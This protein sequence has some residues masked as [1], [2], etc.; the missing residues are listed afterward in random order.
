MDSSLSLFLRRFYIRRIRTGRPFTLSSS[1]FTSSSFFF[2]FSPIRLTSGIVYLNLLYATSTTSTISTVQIHKRNTMLSGIFYVSSA[3]VYRLQTVVPIQ[4]P[5]ISWVQHFG[6]ILT[7]KKARILHKR[8]LH[9][10]KFHDWRCVC[11]WWKKGGR[12][13][14]WLWILVVDFVLTRVRLHCSHIDFALCTFFMSVFYTNQRQAEG[15]LLN[16]FRQ[17]SSKLLD[18]CKFHMCSVLYAICSDPILL[19]SVWNRK[20]KG[21]VFILLLLL[22]LWFF[23]LP[24]EHTLHVSYITKTI[25]HVYTSKANMPST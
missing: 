25:Y 11:V 15:H 10:I 24:W 5:F 18:D 12:G 19:I 3:S 8:K 4:L 14:E 20:S 6:S 2:L 17:I 16:T 1:S 7:G 13:G 22:L 23:L 21:I 9:R